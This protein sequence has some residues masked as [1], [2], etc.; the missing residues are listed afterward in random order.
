MRPGALTSCMPGPGIRSSLPA[1]PPAIWAQPTAAIFPWKQT[2]RSPA[3][4]TF[5]QVGC[6]LYHLIAQSLVIK[7]L[8]AP[9]KQAQRCLVTAGKIN[10]CQVLGI[11]VLNT[12]EVSEEMNSDLYED[13]AQKA[14]SGSIYSLPILAEVE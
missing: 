4:E 9:D 2:R 8:I 11:F 6:R 13:L 10:H 12:Y 5:G 3:K 7:L 14:S 1:G